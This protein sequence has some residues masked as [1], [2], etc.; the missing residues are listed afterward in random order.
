MLEESLALSREIGARYP[1]GYGLLD[2]GSL[3]DDADETGLAVQLTVLYFFY[4]I[5]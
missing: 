4:A 5:Q 3:A 2:L 1:E